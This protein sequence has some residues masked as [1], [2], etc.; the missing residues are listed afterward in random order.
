MLHLEDFSVGAK[1]AAGPIAVTAA[2]IKGF[3]AAFDPQPFHLDEVAAEA[4]PFAGLAASGWHTGAMTMRLLVQAL[5]I[6]GGVIGG[7]VDELRW[8]RPVRPGDALRVEAEVLEV[9]VSGS[10]PTQ[11]WVRMRN[12]T[13]NQEDQPVQSF[14]ANLVVPRRGAP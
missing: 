2:E 6:A 1:F 8:L 11:G 5:P 9:R 12:T 13:Y 3:A 4:T 10:R 14:V 7:G